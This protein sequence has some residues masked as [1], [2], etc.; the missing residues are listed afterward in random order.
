MKQHALLSNCRFKW[1]TPALGFMM[2]WG[3]QSISQDS[4][5]NGERMAADLLPKTLVAYAEVPRPGNLI[6]LAL[7]HPMRRTIEAMPA[8][9]AV[10][11]S[12]NLSQVRHGIAAFEGSMGRPWN[13]A[14]SVLTDGGVHLA[15]DGPTQGAALLIRSSSRDQ[16]ERFRS[17]VLA[18][19]QLGQG[20]FGIAEQAVYRGFTVYS[21]GNNAKMVLVDNWFLMTNKPELGKSIIDRY[22][23][24]GDDSFRQSDRFAAVKRSAGQSLLAA[25]VDLQTIRDAGVAPKLYSGKT[26]NPA[27]EAIFGGIVSNLQ[28]APSIFATLNIASSG[29]DLTIASPHLA[30]WG[31]GRE[32]FFGEDGHAQ[33]PPL[34]NVPDRIFALSAHRDLSQMWLRAPDLMTDK[35]NED[36]AKADSGLTT[37]FSGR[38]FG[39]DILGSLQ[40][41]LQFVVNRQTFN[42]RS[43]Q[44]AI[45]LPA[46]AIQFRMLTPE[47][48]T[49]DFRRVFQNVIGFINVVGAMQ[50]QPQLD[51]GFEQSGNATLITTEY[52]PPKDEQDRTDAAIN[53]N[54]SPTLA[55]VDDRMVISSTVALARTLVDAKPETAAAQSRPNTIAVLTAAALSGTLN[56]NKGQLVAQNML[57]KGHGPDQAQAEIGVL[58]D[59]LDLFKDLKIELNVQDEQLKLKTEINLRS[60]K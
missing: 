53:Y 57:E 35:A 12:N 8:V 41:G 40:P 22:I 52:V 50:G 59:V 36:L 19:S 25:C 21:L 30:Q 32:Y 33:A 9:K 51:L 43:P 46:F 45:K 56:D 27:A 44:P 38:D 24:G 1:M 58:F 20:N 6:D 48:T 13:E 23:D 5:V 16:L 2:L 37:F 14:I 34:L 26:D 29:I 55:F 54:F 42:P 39:E 11:Q 60:D 17:F 31:N 3:G 47:E 10:A 18:I 4:V 7:D 28:H 49:R 15:F